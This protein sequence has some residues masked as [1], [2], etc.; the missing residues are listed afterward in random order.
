MARVHLAM[1]AAMLA[2]DRAAQFSAAEANA[3]NALSLARTTHGPTWP[4]VASKSLQTAQRE[5]LRNSSKYCVL[6]AIQ[7]MHTPTPVW[8]TSSGSCG[9]DRSSCRRGIPPLPSRY[10]R[11]PVD[12]HCGTAKL[13]LGAD[14]EAVAWL[15]RSI[16]A[17]RNF[18]LTHFVLAAAL[19]LLG[20]MDEARATAKAGLALHPDLRSVVCAPLYTATMRRILL[21]ESASAWVCGWPECRK[22]DVPAR[23]KLT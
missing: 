18:P 4:W 21:G 1:G 10:R 15:Q 13:Q 19:G 7:P 6:I 5:G 14:A 3:I 16:D 20:A 23:Y 8:Q 9:R 17:N 12:A 11:L 22:G 2:R